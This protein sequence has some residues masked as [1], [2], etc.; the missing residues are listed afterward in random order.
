MQ[1]NL[2]CRVRIN[3]VLSEW[4]ELMIGLLEGVGASPVKYSNFAEMLASQLRSS[5]LGLTL[6]LANVEEVWL[7]MLGFVDDK[8]LLATSFQEMQDMLD[9]VARV[10]RAQLTTYTLPKSVF[11]QFVGSDPSRREEVSLRLTGMKGDGTNLGHQQ[12]R[13]QSKRDV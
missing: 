13:N 7:G 3:K 12:V 8:A 4:F 2:K 1:E 6:K 10:V 9:V 5:K 11:I